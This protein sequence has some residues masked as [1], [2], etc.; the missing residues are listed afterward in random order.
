M[1]LR[2]WTFVPYS[3]NSYWRDWFLNR[4]RSS[5]ITSYKSLFPVVVQPRGLAVTLKSGNGY[6]MYYKPVIDYPTRDTYSLNYNTVCL[7]IQEVPFVWAKSKELNDGT[8]EV[9]YIEDIEMTAVN[10]DTDMPNHKFNSKSAERQMQELWC[11]WCRRIKQ[12]KISSEYFEY[13]NLVTHTE[14]P[15][16]PTV[17]SVDDT[18]EQ[19]LIYCRAICQ[20]VKDVEKYEQD[21]PYIEKIEKLDQQRDTSITE[22][23]VQMCST[24]FG[25][26]LSKIKDPNVILRHLMCYI[27]IRQLPKPMSY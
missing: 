11:E 24:F 2:N 3:T 22:A 5:R 1:D 18:D 23:E 7:G 20:Y 8:I 26:F 6:D 9:N 19:K 15:V 10:S 12:L 21:K 27:Y 17:P 4:I 14:P 16:E 25:Y 13:R